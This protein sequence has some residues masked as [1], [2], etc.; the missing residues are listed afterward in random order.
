MWVITVFSSETQSTH[1]LSNNRDF[2]A[3]KFR[4]FSG[5]DKVVSIAFILLK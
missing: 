4:A 2:F 5:Y 1:K 3:Q